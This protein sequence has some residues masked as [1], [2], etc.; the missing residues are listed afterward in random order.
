M[1]I[2]KYPFYVICTFRDKC[3]AV[4]LQTHINSLSG[5]HLYLQDLT[6]RQTGVKRQLKSN[7]L[8]D[9][10]VSDHSCCH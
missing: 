5:N 3:F 10:L 2:K 1:E 6:S 4:F 8:A 9:Q 7:S